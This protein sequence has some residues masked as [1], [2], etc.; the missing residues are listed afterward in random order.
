MFPIN[1]RNDSWQNLLAGLGNARDKSTYTHI[2]SHDRFSP[3]YLEQLY[4]H[5][6]VAARIC[7]LVPHE[8]LRQGISIRVN[9]QEFKK[10]G[11]N[12]V[13]RD[14]LIKS[15]VFGVAFIYVGVEDGQ[16]QDQPLLAQKVKRVRFLN[17]LTTKELS[18]HSF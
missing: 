13:L 15:R 6:D 2:V 4:V 12:E 17:V 10:D 1:E 11:L 7:E 14:V 8:M 16:T 3:D 5:D 9:E 18:H